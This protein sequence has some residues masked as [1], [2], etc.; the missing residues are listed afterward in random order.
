[1]PDDFECNVLRARMVEIVDE[2]GQKRIEAGPWEQGAFSM[3]FFTRDEMLQL[4]VGMGRDGQPNIGIYDSGY[5]RFSIILLSDGKLEITAVPERGV[6]SGF[7]LTVTEAPDKT[8][9]RLIDKTGRPRAVFGIDSDDKPFFS[10]VE[11]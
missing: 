10:V 6:R 3:R 8:V 4:N 11:Q 2:E 9:M 1:M 7:Q 5:P